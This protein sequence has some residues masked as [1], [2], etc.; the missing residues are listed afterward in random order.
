MAAYTSYTSARRSSPVAPSNFSSRFFSLGSPLSNPQPRRQRPR[1]PDGESEHRPLP[2]TWI[3]LDWIGADRTGRRNCRGCVNYCQVRTG[4]ICNVFSVKA[5]M[6]K[7]DIVEGIDHAISV[8]SFS[9]FNLWAADRNSLGR[10]RLGSD[11]R[12][13]GRPDELY[14]AAGGCNWLSETFEKKIISFSWL[15]C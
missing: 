6:G 5:R 12:T 9:K 7:N 4:R 14:G 1:E 13:A 8:N 2:S 3:G 11:G 10:A 15:L